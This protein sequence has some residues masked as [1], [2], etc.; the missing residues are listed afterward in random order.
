MAS[1][2][3]YLLFICSGGQDILNSRFNLLELRDP[4]FC[5]LHTRFITVSHQVSMKYQDV[6][7][8][9]IILHHFTS[10]YL[11]AGEFIDTVVAWRFSW[12]F[13]HSSGL[14][15]CG[16]VPFFPQEAHLGMEEGKSW[17]G[18]GKHGG[19]DNIGGIQLGLGHGVILCFP[20]PFGRLRMLNIA[21]DPSIDGALMEHSQNDNL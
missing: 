20:K 11:I 13:L 5:C 8:C 10:C 9:Y 4:C 18:P 19:I 16:D 7:S 15:T 3:S 17:H 6:T 12:C 1:I 2:G 21:T 14:R